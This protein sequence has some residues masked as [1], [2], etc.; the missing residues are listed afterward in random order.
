MSEFRSG[1]VAL[2]G[3]PNVGKS[4]LMNALLG[5][6]VSIAT[7][8]PQT[9]RNR[10][11][12]VHTMPGR[13]QLI[14]VDTPGLHKPH[15]RLNE[16]MVRTAMKAIAG[17]DLVL[18]IVDAASFWAGAGVVS[19]GNLAVAERIGSLGLPVIVAINK[20]DRLS[21]RDQIL[22]MIEACQ[23]L[24]PLSPKAVIPISALTGDNLGRL[25]DLLMAQMPVGPQLYPDD[26]IT[27]QAERF[28]AGEFVRE[29]LTLQTKRELP[30]SCAVTISE[31]RDD[32]ERD[33]LYLRAVIHVERDSQ[34]G[35]VIGKR[36]ARLKQI[37][38][39]AR[40][41]LERFFGKKVYLDLH[42]TVD[43]GWPGDSS[44]LQRLGYGT[45]D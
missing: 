45:G 42:V 3:L 9:T 23:S 15:K 41:D 35:I 34:K 40:G 39:Q 25:V 29:K 22:P 13:G 37:G 32:T 27:D 20:I 11:V 19:P 14:Y 2:A 1:F 30:Y 16:I 36:G 7:S 26:I 18:A 24:G 8:R 21:H 31:F 10:I 38:S 12:G 17:T 5:K 28:I 4:T 33:V 6:K 44:A 43:K